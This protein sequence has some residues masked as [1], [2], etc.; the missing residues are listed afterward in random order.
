MDEEGRTEGARGVR[1]GPCWWMPRLRSRY[2]ALCWGYAG[3]RVWRGQRYGRG[4]CGGCV[5]QE[6]ER[7]MEMERDR[8]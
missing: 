5:H 7:E 6:R 4:G 1:V 3:W 8:S 2:V